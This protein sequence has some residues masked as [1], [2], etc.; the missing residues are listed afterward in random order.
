MVRNFLEEIRKKNEDE[1]V[2][3]GPIKLLINQARNYEDDRL[4]EPIRSICN[5]YYF[6][7][8]QAIGAI[9]YDNAVWQCSRQRVPVL[10]HQ[11]FN[12]LVGQIQSV[13]KHLVDQTSQRAVV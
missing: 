6:L 8:I 10:I 12:P 2:P 7:N 3:F 11:P 5:K 1:S 13:V 4:G 9:Q